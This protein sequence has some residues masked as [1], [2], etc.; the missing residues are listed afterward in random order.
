MLIGEVSF[1]TVIL[2]LPL[3]AASLTP[4]N[5][6]RRKIICAMRPIAFNDL[7]DRFGGV[8]F[9]RISCFSVAVLLAEFTLRLITSS[10][11]CFFTIVESS[12]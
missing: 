1:E 3:R 8:F 11:C 5:P 7:I 10:L 9:C 4:K 2:L 12:D 6:Q